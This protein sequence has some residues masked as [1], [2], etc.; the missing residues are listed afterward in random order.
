MEERVGEH[1]PLNIFAE[2]LG[3]TVNKGQVIVPADKGSG[4][5][6]GILL[7][8][9]AGLLFFNYHLNDN[10]IYQRPH[11]KE[12]VNVRLENYP[13]L[14]FQ[15]RGC[16][17]DDSV[18]LSQ[19]FVQISTMGINMEEDV[20]SGKDRADLF[21]TINSKHLIQKIPNHSESL[22]LK[23]IL[24]NE[25]PLFFEYSINKQIQSIIT[26][27][28]E[29]S[30]PSN[31]I[32]YFLSIK[33]DE[34]ICRLLVSLAG[35]QEQTIYPI[36]PND[37]RKIYSVKDQILANLSNPPII[38]SLAKNACM[39][40]TKL[41]RLFKQVFGDSIFNY[42][43]IRRIQKAA[44]LLKGGGQTVSSVGYTLGFTNLSHFSR[45]FERIIGVKPKAYCK[46]HL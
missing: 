9:F 36:H 22:I 4:Y 13:Y 14:L 21:I 7:D 16:L 45:I 24:F 6:K 8:N 43:E 2:M 18:S 35:R 32:S 41:K 39:S 29:C 37:L 20:M 17:A 30:V 23:S 12:E 26:E 40:E 34:L 27:I 28:I 31:F 42:Y 5:F 46:L 44:Q 19:R 11:Q 38:E 33:V 15:F 10:L 25:R 3:T 1:G